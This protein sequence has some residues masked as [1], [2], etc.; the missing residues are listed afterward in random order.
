MLYFNLNQA[1]KICHYKIGDVIHIPEGEET[2]DEIKKDR[3]FQ[4]CV[5]DD[6]LKSARGP[7]ANNSAG[8]TDFKKLMSG[9][10]QEKRPLFM[11]QLS[12]GIAF[13]LP[14]L[15]SRAVKVD[16]ELTIL[17]TNTIVE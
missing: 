4:I 7:R 3:L 17:R 10:Y 16:L 8:R 14:H 15:S 12:T 13:S 6:N 2:S 9:L 1:P 5:I 11:I